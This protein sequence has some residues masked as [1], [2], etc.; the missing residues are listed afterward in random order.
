MPRGLGG[1]FVAAV[2]RP[3]APIG[4]LKENA[5]PKILFSAGDSADTAWMDALV[6]AVQEV[7][8]DDRLGICRSRR[9]EVPVDGVQ[10]HRLGEALRSAVLRQL[11]RLSVALVP[12][13]PRIIHSQ[14]RRQQLRIASK[15]H[16][17]RVGE[18]QLIDLGGGL[19]SLLAL[20]T[21]LALQVAQVRA[22]SPE[23]LHEVAALA[24]LQQSCNVVL[25]SVGPPATLDP[26]GHVGRGLA[27][28][29]SAQL[30][31]ERGVVRAT[32]PPFEVPHEASLQ[33]VLVAAGAVAL[34]GHAS[35]S[36]HS[37]PTYPDQADLESRADAKKL[38][39]RRWRRR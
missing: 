20:Q 1:R 24:L 11:A 9:G 26:Q 32:R 33:F 5:T 16:G 18:H 22:A 25:G 39:W 19:G 13:L 15:Q 12:V 37:N 34:H 3:R 38:K 30:L 6:L 14:A 27:Q 7:L 4:E 10:H 35:R 8:A 17:G 21:A 36:G 2:P 28:L 29:Q 31:L 23:L